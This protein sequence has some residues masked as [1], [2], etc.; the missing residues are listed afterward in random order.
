MDR[1]LE[2]WE[3]DML[4]GGDGTPEMEAALQN[5]PNAQQRLAA[6]AQE[7][8]TLRA[9]L[10]HADCPSPLT[11]GELHLGLLDESTVQALRHH[12]DTCPTCPEEFAALRQVMER[13]LTYGAPARSLPSVP[14][15]VMQVA[16]MLGGLGAALGTAPALRGE[17]RSICYSSGDYLLSLTHQPNPQ[18]VA[19]IGSLFADA[20]VGQATLMQGTT[21]ISQTSLTESATFSFDAIPPGTYNIVIAMPQVE[22]VIPDLTL[23]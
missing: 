17:S 22:L 21:V 6:L 12:L 4:L 2:D 18:G 13:P 11:L 23:A 7:E 8:R 5:N 15:L 1:P 10:Y 14:R 9:T 3:L 16:E 19:L 20:A